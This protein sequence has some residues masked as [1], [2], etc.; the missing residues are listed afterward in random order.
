MTGTQTRAGAATYPAAPWRL[1]GQAWASF[2]ALGAARLPAVPSG[3]RP[4]RIAGRGFVMA[5]WVDYQEGSV[6]RYGELYAAVLGTFRGRPTATVTHMWVDS[7]ASRAGGREL[8]GYPKELAE[9]DLR[10]DPGGTA[11]AWADGVE[12]ARGSFRPAMRLG[13]LPALPTGTVQVV[14]GAP[15]PIRAVI[16]GRPALGRGR[17]D[18]APGGP[19][20][21]LAGAHRLATIGVQDFR[22]TFG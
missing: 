3:F 22:A 13:R 20:G 9:F 4:L 18:P 19:L 15:T 21:F 16:G 10:I 1:G 17:L 5:G 12:L 7:E 14:G 11:I 8:W 6:L 2:F